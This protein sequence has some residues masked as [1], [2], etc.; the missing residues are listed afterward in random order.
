MRRSNTF[1]DEFVFSHAAPI[2]FTGCFIWL[3][4]VVK[5]G[6]GKTTDNGMTRMAH[7]VIWEARNGPVPSGMVLRHQCDTPACVNPDHMLVGTTKDNAADMVERGRQ[8]SGERCNLSKLS[9]ETVLALRAAA[10]THYQVAK[11]FGLKRGVVRQI[12]I[13]ETW[14]HLL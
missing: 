6:Y 14:R 8:A 9:N 2:P 4:G 10:G 13:G 11:R 1:D 12:R 3:G 7:R 5:G